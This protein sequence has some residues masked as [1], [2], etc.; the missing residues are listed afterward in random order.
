MS[1][2]VYILECNDKT[3]YIGYTNDLERRIFTHNNLKTG[4]KY[5]KARRPVCLV[6]SEKFKTKVK[7]MKREYELKQMTR[8]EKLDI[9]KQSI[10]T[11]LKNK[12]EK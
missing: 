11:K 12:Y 10:S 3:L 8:E 9:I 5:T 2:F 7:A 4:A 6:Y 1:H